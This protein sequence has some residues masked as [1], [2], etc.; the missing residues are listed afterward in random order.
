MTS[1]IK[2]PL[3]VAAFIMI[4]APAQAQDSFS[5]KIKQSANASVE[6]NYR[7]M[8]Q[9]ATRYCKRE[10]RRLDGSGKDLEARRLVKVCIAQLMDRA[11][12]QIQDP[13]LL[14]YHNERNGVET[15]VVKNE[16]TTQQ[17]R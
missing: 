12:K 9:Q 2:I 14:A 6:E 5:A 11:V 15:A 7:S 3:T 16:N 4:A 8:E 10:G 13:I 1:L 17:E